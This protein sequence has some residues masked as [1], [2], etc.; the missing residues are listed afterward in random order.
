MPCPLPA[1][2][3]TAERASRESGAPPE[4]IN[5]FAL[6]AGVQNP[7]VALPAGVVAGQMGQRLE[8]TEE[9]DNSII[10]STINNMVIMTYCY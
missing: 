6:K 10:I 2:R 1:P 5:P 4:A 3:T 9:R 7:N 8:L